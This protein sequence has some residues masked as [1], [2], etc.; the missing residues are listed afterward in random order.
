MPLRDVYGPQFDFPR[1]KGRDYI[2]Y[3]LATS[4]RSGSTWLATELWRTGIM[5]NPMEYLGEEI[6]RMN[7]ERAEIGAGFSSYWTWLHTTRSSPNGVFGCK[8]FPANVPLCQALDIDWWPRLQASYRL[9]YL[10]REND[11][12]QAVSLARVLQDG[13][14]FDYVEPKREPVY[15]FEY[16]HSC[17]GQIRASQRF[18]EEQR[19]SWKQPTLRITYEA[20]RRDRS[21][22]V[23]QIAEFL[24]VMLTSS[25]LSPIVEVQRQSDALNHEWEA[26]YRHDATE[27]VMVSPP[28]S[29]S[30]PTSTLL[31]G[32]LR[33]PSSCSANPRTAQHHRD[34][35]YEIVAQP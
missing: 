10:V 13:R 27:R 21:A 34:S 30:L 4:Q 7:R 18:W 9:I 2:D 35:G 23:A 6:Q 29:V 11:I 28:A 1:Y 17:V 20:L 3:I 26:R 8:V 15:D 14:W 5:G 25:S 16:I 12:A 19:R 24:G 31:T 22:V 32:S 33:C